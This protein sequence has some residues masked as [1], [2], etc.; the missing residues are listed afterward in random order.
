[1]RY[2]DDRTLPRPVAACGRSKGGA[3]R[4]PRPLGAPP[5]AQPQQPAPGSRWLASAVARREHRATAAAIPPY[6]KIFHSVDRSL[7]ILLNMSLV[8]FIDVPPELAE[9][10]ARLVRQ[11]DPKRYG[12]V[13]QN[14]HLLSKHQ[15]V[16]VSGRSLLPEIRALWASLSPTEQLE[17]KTCAAQNNYNG[18]TQ[19]VQDMSY[20]LK[21]GIPGIAT[22]SLY[23]Q[24][25]VGRLE[26]GAPASRA[27]LVQY[28]P[29]RYYVQKKV[30]GTKGQ[31]IDV[32]IYEKLMLP[33]SVG[34][35]YAANLIPTSD[36]P[37]A[38]FYAD[39]VSHYQGRDIH[40]EIGFNIPFET[41][42]TRQITGVAEVPGVARYYDLR[43]E[44][45][46]VRGWFEWDNVRSYH[47]GTNYARDF[48]CSDVNNTLTRVNYQIEKSWE[49]EVLPFGA[50]FDSI[51]PT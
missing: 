27:L 22:P 46:D 19:F 24:Y 7:A 37:V 47:S 44:F 41:D 9:L 28:H 35:S 40:N 20:R 32:P 50:A 34:L 13:A 12:S 31:Y 49:E 39:V 26:I 25:K 18:W 45:T 15:K 51:Y 3:Q 10:F 48:R 33:L 5:A 6:K 30:T 29:A 8:G 4:P 1:M 14:G 23:H 43:L 21:Y 2:D 42:W 11:N 38:R 36:N 17:W 16:D